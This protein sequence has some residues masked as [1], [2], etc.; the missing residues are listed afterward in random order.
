MG[1]NN[2]QNKQMKQLRQGK[3]VN[4]LNKR[5]NKNNKCNEDAQY[6]LSFDTE[7]TSF[8]F[9]SYG[10]TGIISSFLTDEFYSVEYTLATLK[11]SKSRIG[12]YYK[13]MGMYNGSDSFTPLYEIILGNKV[14]TQFGVYDELVKY[15][16]R[17]P[18]I[19]LTAD[20]R[21]V[22]RLSTL[23]SVLY[24]QS[25]EGVSDSLNAFM[26]GMNFKG[27]PNN[28]LQSN[29]FPAKLGVTEECIIKRVSSDKPIVGQSYLTTA[30]HLESFLASSE[31]TNTKSN[32]D[33]TSADTALQSLLSIPRQYKD[34]LHTIVGE[35]N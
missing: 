33:T 21:L 27:F 26:Q 24:A 18:S 30:H 14:I 34:L 35:S 13:L 4:K 11:I 31:S 16:N 12:L 25:Y 6:M 5:L 15:L 3:E 32:T 23:S 28:S 1:K 22:N 8:P 29:G 10:N 9:E 20:N 17:N 2:K 19:T 7:T